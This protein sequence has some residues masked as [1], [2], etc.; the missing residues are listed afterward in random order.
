MPDNRTLADWN[1]RGRTALITG[2]AGDIGQAVARR[3]AGSGAALSLLDLPN[4]PLPEIASACAGLTSAE[5]VA[6]HFVDVTDAAEV[7]TALAKTAATLGPPQLVFNNAGIQGDFA[8]TDG[9]PRE[10]FRTVLD[11][12]VVGVFNVLKSAG[13]LL[14]ESGLPG[15]VVNTASMAFVG[16]PNM[17]AYGASKS[18]VVAMTRTAAKDLAPLGVRVN[19]V[20]PGFIGPGRMWERQVE[21]QADVGSQYFPS[22]PEEVAEEMLRSV[23]MRRYGSVDEVASVVLFLLSDEASYLTGVNIEIAGGVG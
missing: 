12:N 14:R 17:I 3:L 8:T 6:S 21:L 22:D 20:S 2:A 19:A 9:Y 23:P 5:Q 15:S 13:T 18:A 1:F 7:E 16:P 10:G 11:V 4:T